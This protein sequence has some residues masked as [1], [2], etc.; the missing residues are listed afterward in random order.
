MRYLLTA[1]AVG[2][3]MSALGCDQT[4][5]DQRTFLASCEEVIK[6][7]L[8]SPSSY[9][10]INEPEISTSK[11]AISDDEFEELVMRLPAEL[12]QATREER[13]R[14]EAWVEQFNF[15]T[16]I[17][18]D[19]ANAYG[20]PLRRTSICRSGTSYS[21]TPGRFDVSSNSVEVDG[22][23]STGWFVDQAKKLLPTN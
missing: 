14:G 10:R 12:Q 18:Y 20:T 15:V 21:G 23:T 4:P 11:S 3:L 1:L 6:E 9:R 2:L 17:E 7:R 13:L 16:M 22:R 5:Q 19:A 8:K